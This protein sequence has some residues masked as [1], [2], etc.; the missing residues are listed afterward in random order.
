PRRG[1][2]LPR[3]WDRRRSA[4]A[5][6]RRRGGRRRAAPRGAGPAHP[7]ARRTG[8][9]RG[10]RVG[11]AGGGGRRRLRLQRRGHLPRARA[12]DAVVD[13]SDAP[14]TPP[15]VARRVR[16]PGGEGLAPTALPPLP[17]ARRRRAVPPAHHPRGHG[18]DI[19][20]RRLVARAA[21]LA[22]GPCRGRAGRP[23][24]AAGVPRA[25]A[26][27]A[28]V[29]RD[30]R[31]A[32]TRG[33]RLMLATALETVDGHRVRVARLGAGPPLVLLHGYPEN[34]QIW[35]E[36][37]PR[38]AARFAVTAFDWPGMGFSEPWPGGKTPG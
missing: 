8:E 3:G 30:R 12:G 21:P 10:A 1:R 36:V 34:L 37:A 9:R 11:R 27:R 26:P 5:R 31:R 17:A 32:G 15:A 38:L 7:C 23:G 25:R 22:H 19:G 28:L 14:R 24:G 16:V 18:R 13:A 33:L 35:C 2:L 29:A 20:P 6:A 4:R